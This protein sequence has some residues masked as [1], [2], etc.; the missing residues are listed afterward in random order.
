MSQETPIQ[1]LTN[2]ISDED[3]KLV[4]SILNDLTDVRSS[5][6]AQPAQQAQSAQQGEQLTP[7]QIKSIQMQRQM[8]MQQQQQNLMNQQQQL[9]QQQKMNQ[10]QM[11]S[12]NVIQMESEGIIEDI[13][14]ESKSI[15]LVILLSVFL[16]IEQVDN[17][18]KMQPSLFVSESGSIN[19]QAVLIKALIIGVLFY[20]IKSHVL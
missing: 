1:N 15:I 16:N 9:S 13:K 14:R 7:E 12:R 19:I 8:A 20:L 10:Q 11:G 5:Q 2:T 17:I 4:D 6:P 18:F 3:S